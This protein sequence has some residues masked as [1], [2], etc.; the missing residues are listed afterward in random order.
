MLAACPLT[1]VIQLFIP[2]CF[3]FSLVCSEPTRIL[4]VAKMFLNG[5]VICDTRC[6][7]TLPTL[8]LFCRL[9]LCRSGTMLMQCTNLPFRRQHGSTCRSV[10]EQVGST[11]RSVDEQVGRTCRSTSACSYMH[12]KY[13][14]LKYSLLKNR[15][16]KY[17]LVHAGQ[18]GSKC[19]SA[20]EHCAAW[21]SCVAR[22]ELC[23]C[24]FLHCV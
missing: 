13:S 24:P 6:I 5:K 16:P 12:V 22:A 2:P 23:C 18:H 19:R 4:R 17:S 7:E 10:N 15:L 14:L 8:C 1:A 9:A 3:L 20:D 11:C 21:I